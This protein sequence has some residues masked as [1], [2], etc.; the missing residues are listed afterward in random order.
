MWKRYLMPIPVGAGMT[1]GLLFAMQLLIQQDVV[2]CCDIFDGPTLD[3]I[4]LEDS[5]VQTNELQPPERIIDPVQPPPI[6][7]PVDTDAGA[8]VNIRHVAP[9]APTG[10]ESF[11]FGPYMSDGPLVSIVRVAPQY[12]QT[13]AVRGIEGWAVVGFDVE[14]DGSTSN[15]HVVDVSHTAFGRPAVRATER[16]R[17]K[18]RVIDGQP[19]PTR[20]V[21]NRFRFELEN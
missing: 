12:P 7:P 14:A 9:P 10:G 19:V 1:F 2:E 13:M 16:F 20:G 18:P 15:I 21:T 8:R 11:N 5:E 3:F 4:K 6:T 17:Y